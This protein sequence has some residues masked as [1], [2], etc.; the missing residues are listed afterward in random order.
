M[1]CF[2]P[3][4]ILLLTA[5]FRHEKQQQQQQNNNKGEG[6]DVRSIS[7]FI[8]NLGMQVPGEAFLDF[9]AFFIIFF[10]PFAG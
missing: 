5:S 7:I 3:I 6:E 1:Y 4:C 8:I 9:V 2:V 10:I